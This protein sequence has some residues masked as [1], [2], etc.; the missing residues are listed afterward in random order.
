MKEMRKLK[1]GI[2]G[3]LGLAGLTGIIIMTVSVVLRY[4]FKLSLSWSDEF[5]RT[6]CIYIYFIGSAMMCAEGGL[7]RLE[8]LDD[9]LKKK[10]RVRAYRTVVKIQRLIETVCFGAFSFQMAQM[11]LGLVGQTSTTSTT[12]AWVSP[13]GCAI[14]MVLMTLISASKLFFEKRELKT[15]D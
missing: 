12:P 2:D 1:S 4:C 5:L 6:L 15:A 10:G 11:T 9:S 8:L 14:G 7:M 13:L 3:F